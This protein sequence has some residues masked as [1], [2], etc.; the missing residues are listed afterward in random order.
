MLPHTDVPVIISS[1]NVGYLDPQM[2]IWPR[3]SGRSFTLKELQGT[4]NVT[5]FDGIS[6]FVSIG[7]NSYPKTIFRFPLRK[8][9]SDL[10]ENIYDIPKVH[11][12]INALRKEAK[13]LLIFLRSV[14]TIEV[15]DILRDGSQKLCFK[16]EILDKYKQSLGRKRKKLLDRLRSEYDS[17]SYNISGGFEFSAK[18]SIRVSGM[19][20]SETEHGESSWLVCNQVGSDNK[21]ILEAAKKQKV[22]PWVGAAFELKEVPKCGGRIFCFLPMPVE[23]ASNLPVHV[24]GTFGLTD[25]RRSLKWREKMTSQQI[26]I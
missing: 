22:F 21:A 23:A 8:K 14:D 9:P 13:L 12:L 24:N 20:L 19:D 15:Y 6:D 17:K 7:M 3:E 16:T 25:D 5:P 18:F 4:D 10:S 2:R 11:T 1:E 26:G